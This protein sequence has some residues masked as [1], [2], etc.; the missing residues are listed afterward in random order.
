[1]QWFLLS[2]DHFGDIVIHLHSQNNHF[3]RILNSMLHVEDSLRVLKEENK[4]RNF[5]ERKD[6][7]PIIE[8]LPLVAKIEVTNRC[9]LRCIMCRDKNDSRLIK[10]LDFSHFIKLQPLFPTLLSAY[11]YGIGEALTYPYVLDMFEMLLEYNVNVGIITNGILINQTL[12]EQWV[13][14]NLYKLSISIDGANKET[15]ERIR[16]GASFEQ[17]M[18]NIA[19]VNNLKKQY[20]TKSPMLTFNFVAMRSNI[21][22]LPA[23]IDLAAEYSAAEVIVNDLIVFFEAMKKEAIEY[24]DPLYQQSVQLA[25]QRACE[26]GVRL[27]L[28][29][30]FRFQHQKRETVND[31]SAE[32]DINPCTEPWSGFWL[33]AD[34]KVTPC[35]YW[36][37]TMGDLTKNDFQSIWNNDAYVHLRSTVNTSKRLQQCRH[38]AIAGMAKRI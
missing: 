30:P 25:H 13:K 1:M 15:Y 23:V 36:M 17:L 7:Q 24:D 26:T 9:N 28:P 12:A 11:L 27:V 2:C 35:C 20:K 18:D 5:R 38:C 6:N 4:A 34:G 32:E 8:S 16:I 31:L 10:D 29:G 33:T 37:K 3:K 14:K 21:S 19:L 22:E